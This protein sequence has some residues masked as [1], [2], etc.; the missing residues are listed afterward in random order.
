MVN[1]FCCCGRSFFVVKV[2]GNEMLVK[3]VVKDSDEDDQSNKN[4]HH[5]DVDH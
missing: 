2:P 5:C 4:D 1:I 3:R